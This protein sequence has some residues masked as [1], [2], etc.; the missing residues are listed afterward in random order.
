MARRRWQKVWWRCADR[1]AEAMHKKAVEFAKKVLNERVFKIGCVIRKELWENPEKGKPPME[2]TMAYTPNGDWI[3]S[4][5]E[6]Q[7]LVVK[8]GIQ[9]Q[10][11]KPEHCV[12]SIGW[13]TKSGKW[14]GW[15]HHAIYGFKTGS[16]SCVKKGHGLG[17]SSPK[18]SLAQS[19]R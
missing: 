8:L 9:P 14:Y 5:R 13:S 6:T 17:R 12:C 7:R 11:S 10:K 16:M 3:G 1:R 18:R 2:M 19:W 4:P 15:S